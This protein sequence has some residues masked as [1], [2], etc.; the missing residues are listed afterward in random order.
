MKAMLKPYVSATRR[1]LKMTRQTIRNRE[2]VNTH[3]QPGKI[4]F[5]SEISQFLG[6]DEKWLIETAAE[7][8]ACP[9]AWKY[10]SGLGSPSRQT[11][12]YAKSLDLAEGFALWSLVK[13]M[14]PHVVVELGTQYGLSAHL[15]KVA[16]KAYVPQHELILCDLE[17]HLRFIKHEECTFVLGDA[18]QTL[19]QIFATRHVDV[20]HN[21]A[22]PYHLIE[23]SVT[24]AL[25]QGVPILTFHDV[26]F[27]HP[28]GPFK[29]T[30]VSL[31]HE[32]KMQH[33]T[34]YAQYGTWERHVMAE[35]LDQRIWEHDDA[36]NDR[37]R[38]HIFDSLFGFGV[39]LQIAR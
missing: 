37:H 25:Q 12:G 39:S 9:A 30:G 2:T 16:L 36:V 1:W 20:L 21:D 7:Y 10:L 8:R 29:S 33:S 35:I 3:T 18:Y 27:R 13:K 15:W 5:Q 6:C 19:R 26:G 38:I 31:S 22:H 4:F 34:D 17:D 28:R 14:R 11:D 24:E 23:W 32:E